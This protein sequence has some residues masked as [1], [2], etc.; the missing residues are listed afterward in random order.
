MT[1]TV[2]YATYSNSTAL[3]S[4]HL[5]DLLK[6]AGHTVE[7]LTA[8][9]ATAEALQQ[10]DLLI[11]ASPSWD[12]DGEQGMPH[13][14]FTDL[15]SRLGDTFA[16]SGKQTAIMALGDSSFTYFCGAATHLT[17]WLT[18]KGGKEVLPPLKIDQYYANEQAAQ[19]QIA[20]WSKSLLSAV[21]K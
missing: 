14:D 21:T 9:E 11:L 7:L 10:P 19:Q 18:E 15:Q 6:A 17:H 1:A 16:L 20:D 3:A 8:S 13:E 12:Y 5:V 2:L 4:E